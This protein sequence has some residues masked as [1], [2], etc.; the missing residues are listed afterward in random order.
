MGP[1][2]TPWLNVEKAHLGYPKFSLMGMLPTNKFSLEPDVAKEIQFVSPLTSS[3]HDLVY[4]FETPLEQPNAVPVTSEDTRIKSNQSPLKRPRSPKKLVVR[5]HQ[6]RMSHHSNLART[7]VG[8]RELAKKIGETFLRW[9]STPKTV[10]I[11]SKLSDPALVSFT[12]EMT[13]WLLQFGLNVHVQQ[14]LY[15]EY[16][17]LPSRK[18]SPGLE[19]NLYSWTPDQLQESMSAIDFVITFGGDGTVLFAAWLFQEKVPPI[20]PFNMGSLGFLTVFDSENVKDTI[21]DLVQN[22]EVDTAALTPQGMRMNFRMRF[23][24]RIL[25]K[26]ADEAD[27]LHSYQVLNDLVVD[28]GPSPFL[29]KLELYDSLSA[30]GSVVHPDVSAILVTPI[31]PHTLSFRPM[32]LPDTMEVKILVPEDSRATA[33]VS[34]DGRHRVHMQAGDAIHISTSQ[35]P[36]PTV[37][38]VTQ[39]EDWFVGLERCLAWNKRERQKGK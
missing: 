8:L 24:C 36:V 39:N 4:E 12:M 5:K 18:D 26:N 10:M 31:C 33:W 17:E 34:F 21:K 19:K 1:L 13:S 15:Q 9:E 29:S 11:V 32:I 37:C 38:K 25:R 7:A 6:R 28:R 30:G 3:L 20:V 35:Y 2:C 16:I 23:E 22:E 14:P 27:H